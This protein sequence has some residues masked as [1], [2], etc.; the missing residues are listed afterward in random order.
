MTYL[1]MWGGLWG[2]FF[3]AVVLMVAVTPTTVR[4]A[5]SELIGP[6]IWTGGVSLLVALALNGATTLISGLF[7]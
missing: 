7:P 3:A 2:A 1:V 6:A 4:T 5:N